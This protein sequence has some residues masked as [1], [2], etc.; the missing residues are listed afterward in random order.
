MLGHEVGHQRQTPPL[1]HEESLV[2][3][4]EGVRHLQDA[5]SGED[6]LVTHIPGRGAFQRLQQ[7]AQTVRIAVQLQRGRTVDQQSGV[8]G[9]DEDLLDGV[10][11]LAVA[12]SR[13]RDHALA[14]QEDVGRGQAPPQHLDPLH[15]PLAPN[16]L[17][18]LVC[19]GEG[20]QLH[21]RDEGAR[22]LV[23]RRY[24]GQGV[25]HLGAHGEAGRGQAAQQVRSRQPR[26]H[27]AEPAHQGLLARRRPARL[28]PVQQGQRAQ[29]AR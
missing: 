16:Q 3:R 4:I 14:L 12:E 8:G 10:T 21:L 17:R 24:L 29:L 13:K 6:H 23:V 18:R 15:D 5:G 20:L 26:M 7:D 2:H 28:Q 9:G 19:G 25:E 27:V 22:D 1:R 11:T